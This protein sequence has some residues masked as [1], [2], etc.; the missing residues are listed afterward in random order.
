MGLGI[1][2]KIGS[3]IL[4]I[5]YPR[6]CPICDGIIK[7]RSML[8]CAE[9]KDLLQL[10]GQNRCY[11]CG[12]PV[13]EDVEYCFD[14][15]RKKFT[16]IEGRAVYVYNDLMKDS[17]ARFKYNGRVEYADYYVWSIVE[18][19]GNYIRELEV[20]AIIPV[21]IHSTKLNK[22]GYNQAEIIA[23]K[24]GKAMNILVIP[25]ALVRV[26][27][28]SAQKELDNKQREKNLRHAIKLNPRCNIPDDVKK[29]LIVDDIYTTGS[30]I[31]AC[32]KQLMYNRCID[33]YFVSVSIGKGTK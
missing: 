2:K 23:N 25:N 22:R 24:L 1:I 18:N 5:I 29:V 30:T 6:R 32:A 13:S 16:Y 4:D 19:L 17:I 3:V 7:E 33:V 15:S 11:K 26:V 8:C 14:C 27:N 9:C 28:T 31:N 10:V 20:D 21:P 12:K